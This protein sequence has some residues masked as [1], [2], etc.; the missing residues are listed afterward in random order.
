MK[1]LILSMFFPPYNSIASVR[2]GKIAKYLHLHGNDIRVVTA[3][4]LP[5]SRDLLLEVPYNLVRY[6]NSYNFFLRRIQSLRRSFSVYGS[7]SGLIWIL[8]ALRSATAVVQAWKPDVI[9]ASSPPR[10]VLLLAH[11][12]HKVTR[13]PWVADLRDAWA[14]DYRYS[15]PPFRKA[16]ELLQ[17]KTMLQSASGFTTVSEPLAQ[18]LRWR[19]RK[20]TCVILNGFDPD[21]YD[22]QCSTVPNLPLRIVYTGTMYSVQL[23]MLKMFFSALQAGGFSPEQLQV[24]CYGYGADILVNAVQS[25][26]LQHMIMHHG[27]VTYKS[28]LQ[29]QCSA[30]IL[31]FPSYPDRGVY[32]GKLFE[33]LAA[34][35][36]ILYIGPK[37]NVA[38]KLIQN[39]G[40]GCIAD[41]RDDIVAQLRLWIATKQA[42][43]TIPSLPSSVKQGLSREEQTFYLEQFLEEIIAQN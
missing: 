9:L 6:E 43:G 31:L 35:R 7:I 32:S 42:D 15:N 34:Q 41:Q 23:E 37:D 13:V 8:P 5:V 21:D 17:E 2:L 28:S 16:V 24:H 29:I 3:S 30:D 19:Y 18:P 39:R 14:D 12:L 38:A 22:F 36:P 33:Y 4:N 10:S 20:P 26:G 11:L 1:I 25:F 27:L 40:A